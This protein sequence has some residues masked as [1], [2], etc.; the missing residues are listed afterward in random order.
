MSTTEKRI[1]VSL[2]RKAL[3]ELKELE[4][5]FGETTSQVVRLALSS[6]WEKHIIY[7]VPKE[8]KK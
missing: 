6:L 3:T 4:S 1:S 8:N 5:K 2:T 7:Q